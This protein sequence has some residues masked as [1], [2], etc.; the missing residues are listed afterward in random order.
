MEDDWQRMVDES[1]LSKMLKNSKPQTKTLKNKEQNMSTEMAVRSVNEFALF[2][3]PDINIP[4]LI[5]DNLEGE[6]FSPQDLTRISVPGGGGQTF[7]IPSPGGDID[8][9]TVEGI[10]IKVQPVRLYYEQAFGEGEV[11]PPTCYSNDGLTG[12][13]EPGGDC[14]RCPFNEF[15]SATKG[16][17]KACQERRNIFILPA[18]SLLPYVLSVPVMSIKNYKTYLQYLTR[19]GIS[20]KAVTTVVGLEKDKSEAGVAFSKL[21]FREGAPLDDAHKQIVNGYRNAFSGVV[22]KATAAPH[23]AE[24]PFQ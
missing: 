21:T 22:D 2:Q 18:D 6:E 9:K 15:G 20:V 3:N 5:R 8:A 4:E 19:K 7:S 11:T 14:Q 17:G 24:T 1:P 16:K 23:P 13:G 10:I 12:F